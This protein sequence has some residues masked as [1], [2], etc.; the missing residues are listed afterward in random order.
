M[1]T[2]VGEMK[3]MLHKAYNINS[4]T[5]KPKLSGTNYIAS[6]MLAKSIFTGI[7]FLPNS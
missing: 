7:H 2:Y 3:V 5:T 4:K 6:L 1:K